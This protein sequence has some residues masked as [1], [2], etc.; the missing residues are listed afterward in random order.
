VSPTEQPELTPQQRADRKRRLAEVFGDVL[1]DQTRD[2]QA[3]EGEGT[4]SND[5]WLKDQ[6]PP[7]HGQTGQD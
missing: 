3:P 1:P 5:Q 7:H 4:R 6:V 2:D